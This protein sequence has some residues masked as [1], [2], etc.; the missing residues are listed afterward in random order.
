[1]DRLL[2]TLALIFSS[3]AQAAEPPVKPVTIYQCATAEKQ[4]VSVIRLGNLYIY[5]QG[6]ITPQHKPD[7]TLVK[8]ARALTWQ[9][10]RDKHQTLA[11]SFHQQDMHYRLVSDAA[12]QGHYVDIYRGEVRQRHMSC[13]P[14]TIVDHLKYYVD[15][16]PWR[17]S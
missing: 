5:K 16:I 3:P 4:Q 6:A 1:M 11:L 8:A 13:L 2:M 10:K 12:G 14:G 7:I 17:H 9:G 15:D